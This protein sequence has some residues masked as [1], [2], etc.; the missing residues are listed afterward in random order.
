M[1]LGSQSW[2]D[3]T[4][5]VSTLKDTDTEYHLKRVSLSLY[6]GEETPYLSFRMTP[7]IK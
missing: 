4:N 7:H 1:D 2:R 5:Y 3:G 6:R